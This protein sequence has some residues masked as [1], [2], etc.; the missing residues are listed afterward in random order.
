MPRLPQAGQNPVGDVLRRDFQLPAH[1][2]AAKLGQKGVRPVEHHIVEPDAGAHKDLLYARQR[3]Q[4]PQ[5]ADVIRMIDLQIAAGVLPQALPVRTDAA[6]QLG[7]AGGCAEVRGGPA[8]VVNIAFK[9]RI[10]NEELRLRLDGI[11]AAGLDGPPLMEGQGAEA[12]GAE[13]PAAAGQAEFHLGQGRHAAG[14]VIHRMGPPRVGQSVDIVHLLH[15]EGPCG[16]ILHHIDRAVGLRQPLCLDRICIGAL[17][18]E[19]LR[20]PALIVKK[21]VVVRQHHR[22]RTDQ[23]PVLRLKTGPRD[24]G[25]L[26]DGQARGEGVSDLHDGELPHAVG[27]EVGA[28]V[29]QDRPAHPVLPVVIVGK[30]AKARLYP[31]RDDR[32]VLIDAADQVAVDDDRPVGPPSHD[33][34]RGIAVPAAALLRYRIV[35]DHR[36]HI[37]GAHQEAEPRPAKDR[38]ALRILPVR[39][40]DDSHGI[41]AGLQHPADHRRPEGRVIHVGVADH[42]DKIRL[43]DAIP[44]KIFLRYGKKS[45]AH[46]CSP[47]FAKSSSKSRI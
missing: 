31:A 41:P 43:R 24:P 3:A 46:A 12:A 26:G 40:R 35:V 13:A 27:N 25:D 39:L 8:H 23:L 19:A 33:A 14:G 9:L 47:S 32:H 4:A 20:V 17:D 34:A 30:T 11:V 5:Q 16:R 6:P 22:L 1:M 36:I 45:A 29:H 18:A 2:V 38:Y 37:A 44:R 21:L 28:A 42:I 7:P 15:G 10:L